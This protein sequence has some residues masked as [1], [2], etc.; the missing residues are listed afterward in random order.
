MVDAYK[1]LVCEKYTSESTAEA[2]RLQTRILQATQDRRDLR[3]DMDRLLGD[4]FA[5]R[6]ATYAKAGTAHTE[7]YPLALGSGVVQVDGESSKTVLTL[8]GALLNQDLGSRSQVAMQRSSA[9]TL[10]GVSGHIDDGALREWQVTGLALR[11][12][13]DTLNTVPSA[14]TSSRGLGLGVTVLDV[15]HSAQTGRTRTRIAGIE[16]LANI[17]ST[18]NYNDFLLVSIGGELAHQDQYEVAIPIGFEHLWSFDDA[19]N[20]QWR[21]AVSYD[22]TTGN[23]FSASSSLAIRLGEMRNR[24]ILV[25]LGADYTREHTDRD[26]LDTLTLKAQLELNR[27]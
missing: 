16:A 3:V 2:R 10:G 22:V 14:F 11:K 15:H 4:H 8:D 21:N 24:D 27:W 26:I 17:M 5:P 1:D 23:R 7:L 18:P 13:R 19:M 6:E 9:A 12:F 20:W 25:R